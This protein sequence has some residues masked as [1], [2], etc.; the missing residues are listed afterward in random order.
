MYDTCPI[1]VSTP[2]SYQFETCLGWNVPTY[3]TSDYFNTC[4]SGTTVGVPLG[5]IGYQLPYSGNAYCGVF[6]GYSE[7]PP[8][9]YDGWWVEYIQSKL[10]IPLQAGSEYEFSC[11][12]VLSDLAHDYAFWKFGAYFSQSPIS[13]L[14]AKPFSEITPQVMNAQNNF[15]TDTM[16]W[17]EIKGRFIAEGA[18]EY[19]TL[20][21]Y[22]D[23]LSPDT[24][25]QNTGY[26]IDPNNTGGYYFIDACNLTE[27][28]N[29][30]Q[31]PNI[32]SPNGDGENDVWRPFFSANELITIYN[33]WG[34]NVFE[35]STIDEGWEGRNKS[36]QNCSE[37][38]YFFVV[39][40]QEKKS[41]G[42]KGFIQLVR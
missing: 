17:V 35:F 18:E 10:Q 29:V 30:F 33:R 20:G 9:S 4:A 2:S 13:K 6:L 34:I 40:S 41:S 1:S 32:F 12:I 15:I 27:T 7:S 3:A 24:L 23:T 21:F 5:T 36:G 28:G 16:N 11:R 39:R 14:D 37:G 26:P 22:L 25:R 31:Y 42:K 8:N 38:V 19:I